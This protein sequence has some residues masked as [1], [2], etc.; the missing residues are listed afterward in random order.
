[1]VVALLGVLKAGAA[2]V[3]FDPAYPAERLAAMLADSAAPVLIG[4]G[5]PL[6]EGCRRIEMDSATGENPARKPDPASLAYVLYTSGSTGRPRGVAISH[7]ALQNFLNGS[8]ALGLICPGDR[9]LAVTPP[10]F[11]IAGLE[12]FGPLLCGATVV[13]ADAAETRDAP[14][15]AARVEA[16]RPTVMQATPAG[17]QMLLDAGWRPAAATRMLCGGEALARDLAESLLVRGGSLTNLYGPAEAT[18][19]ATLKDVEGPLEDVVVS[20]GGPF[21]NTEAY[22]LDERMEPLGIGVAGELFLGGAQL[23]RGYLGRPAL[24]A[25]RFVANP[26]GPP[27]SRLY[28]TGDLARWGA[29]GELEFLGRLDQQVD[30]CDFASN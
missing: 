14:A 29:T 15:L 6:P 3:P 21:P 20:I 27:G 17:W 23:A 12:L 13:I 26:F 19:W 30:I 10:S 5:I 2:Y 7:A 1:M 25:E 11:D 9:M 8:L 18:I 4:N 24:T 28:R 16:V 22:I